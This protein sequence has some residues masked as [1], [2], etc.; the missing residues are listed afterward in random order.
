MFALAIMACCV[1]VIAGAVFVS[2][3]SDEPSQSIRVATTANAR[4]QEV[5]RLLTDLAGYRSWNPTIVSADGTL[6]EGATLDLRFKNGNGDLESREVTV[7]D[8]NPIHKLRW[9]D[10]LAVPGVRDRETTIR[11]RSFRQGQTVVSVD[12][13]FEGLLAPFADVAEERIELE[14]MLAAL[15]LQAEGT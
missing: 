8:V 11:V 12:E 7:V 1:V 2:A 5:W 13:R 4:E 10:R 15:K 6:E 14:R 9:Q 3:L